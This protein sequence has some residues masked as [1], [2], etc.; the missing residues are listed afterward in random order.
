MS[1]KGRNNGLVRVMGRSTH[2]GKAIQFTAMSV[3]SCRKRL[4]LE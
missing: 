4:T 1:K 3:E 2:I